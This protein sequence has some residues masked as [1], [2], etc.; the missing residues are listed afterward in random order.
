MPFRNDLDRLCEELEEHRVYSNSYFDMLQSSQW[1]GDTY[2]LHRANFFYRTELTVKAIAHVCARAAQEDDVPTLILFS[3]ILNEECG[4]GEHDRCHA[5]LMERA[6]NTFASVAFGLDP[7]H[8][9]AAKESPLV[10]EGTNRYRRRMT[11]LG[12]GS[13]AC[14]LGVALALES[15]AEKML[16]HCRTAFRAHAE[17]F[18]RSAFVREVE[19]YFNVHLDAGVEQRHAMDARDC[20]RRNCRTAQDFADVAR[21]ARG[22]L[23]A[24]LDM[25]QDLHAGAVQ[26]QSRAHA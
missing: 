25:W 8:V 20:V 18:E 10:V 12:S 5:V 14:L 21:G 2:S 19:I 15:H 1:T 3:Y 16:T 24:Q 17:R 22:T 26:L 13:Y 23:E 9:T 6:H 7:L 11:E 4:N